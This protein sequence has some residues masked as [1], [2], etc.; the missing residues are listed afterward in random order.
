MYPYKAATTARGIRANVER[1]GSFDHACGAVVNAD[2][3][4]CCGWLLWP[5]VSDDPRLL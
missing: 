1:S 4:G 5:N 3:L 2:R